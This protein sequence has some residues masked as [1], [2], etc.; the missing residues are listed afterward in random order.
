MKILQVLH[1]SPLLG[2]GGSE[3]YTL[4]LAQALSR[5]HDVRLFFTIP[6]D[7]GSRVEE[8]SCGGISYWALK[9]DLLNYDSPFHEYSRWVE[10]EFI[11]VVKKFNPQVIHFQ[12]LINLSLTLPSLA[13]KMGIP[14]CFTLHDFWLLCPRTFFLNSEMKNCATYSLSRC[15]RCMEDRI[16]YY[17]LSGKGSRPIRY[18]KRCVKQALNFKKKITAF[19]SLGLWRAYWVRKIF[20]AIAMFISPSPFLRTRFVRHGLA[21]QKIIVIPH[22]SDETIFNGIKKKSSPILRF[23]FIGTMRPQKGIYVLLEAFNV[24]AG[25]HELR[26]YGRLTPAVEDDLKKRIKNPHI[27]LMGEL[28]Q[29]DK[30][31]AFSEIDVLIVPSLCCESYSLVLS[32]AFMTKTPVIVSDIGAMAERVRDGEHGFTFPAGN[33][34]KL[35]EKIQIFIDNRGL[36]NSMAAH[37]PE[38]KP[39]ELHAEEISKLYYGLAKG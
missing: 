30:R 29:E 17:A 9:K 28:R 12:H 34:G 25:L 4:S 2:M 1:Y 18:A 24:I 15:M 7:G 31:K 5:E 19:V 23:A 16:G 21:P 26:L 27:Y 20:K 14:C 13:K 10:K 11:R 39:I 32:E 37:L 38:V 3:V 35:A 6:D 33:A 36:I 8:G 22:G